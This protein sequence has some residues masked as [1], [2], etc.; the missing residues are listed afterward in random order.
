M[1]T[2]NIAAFYA[3]S[4]IKAIKKRKDIE[5]KI[6][7]VKAIKKIEDKNGAIPLVALKEFLSKEDIGNFSKNYFSS[8]EFI[9]DILNS[10]KQ[11]DIN[12]PLKYLK[13]VY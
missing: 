5:I 11:K 7:S 12:A 6:A 3:R 4:I 2:K 1:E 8:F 10:S 13:N 9:D